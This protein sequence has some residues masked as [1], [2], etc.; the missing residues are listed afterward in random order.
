MLPTLT[1]SKVY[2]SAQWPERVD[3][4]SVMLEDDR[5]PELL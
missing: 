2:P 1:L 5:A 3:Q 4:E